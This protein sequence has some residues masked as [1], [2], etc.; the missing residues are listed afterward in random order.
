MISI[1]SD[2]KP[3]TPEETQKAIDELFKSILVYRE[4]K[5]IEGNFEDYDIEE[6]PRKLEEDFRVT[7]DLVEQLIALHREEIGI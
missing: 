3:A 6:R 2:S 5:R 4:G 7:N 1:C